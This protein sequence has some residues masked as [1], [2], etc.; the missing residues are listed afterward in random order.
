MHADEVHVLRQLRVREP[1]VPGL[2]GAHRLLDGVARAVEQFLQ[3][4]DRQVP[5]QQH[6]VADEHAHHVDVTV[7]E[8]DRGLQLLLVLLA[9]VIDPGADG[10][11]HVVALREL[12][13]AR[14]RALHAVGAHRLHLAGHQRQVRVDLRLGGQDVVGRILVGA[15]RREREALDDRR[16]RRL[17][18]RTVQVR[19][20]RE[21]ERREHR[22]D[23]QARDRFHRADAAYQVPVL[24]IDFHGSAGASDAPFCSS[25]MEMLSGER[26]NAMCPSRGG[27]RIVTPCSARRWQAA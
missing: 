8:A 6:L 19:P 21:G 11:V 22:R 20:H 18:G 3:F 23:Q 4:R 17:L 14:E 25:S 15:E 26:T 2:R 10:D 7:G 13:N 16:P 9:V 1:G 5:A 27:R 24:G 12:R